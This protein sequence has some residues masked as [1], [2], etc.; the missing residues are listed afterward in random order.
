MRGKPA[1]TTGSAASR[2]I[3]PAHAGKTGRI[4]AVEMVFRDHP[5]ACGENRKLDSE[6]Q[7]CRG[8]PPRMRGKLN[9]SCS[10]L[11]VTRITPAHAGKTMLVW[12]P[13]R[14]DGDHP[15]ACGENDFKLKSNRK[16]VGSPPRMRGKRS[17]RLSKPR[18]AKDHPRACGE[19]RNALLP[20][21]FT[22]GSPPRMRGKLMPLVF[23][24]T[25]HRITPAHAGKTYKIFD[26]EDIPWDH[27]RACGEN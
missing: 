16:E 9:F 25:P 3:T 13:C 20:V 10:L 27:P 12:R 18:M 23:C 2:R 11:G 15:R 19:N 24:T 8:S 17:L 5:R 1:L 7:D 4:H 6:C 26:A 21:V 22:I 14:R